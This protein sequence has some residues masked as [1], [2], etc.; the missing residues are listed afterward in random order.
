MAGGRWPV[1]RNRIR[2]RIRIRFSASC[3][4]GR[5]PIT[6]YCDRGCVGQILHRSDVLLAYVRTPNLAPKEVQFESYAFV[7]AF[8]KTCRKSGQWL[9]Y[10]RLGREIAIGFSP[11]IA[12]AVKYDLVEMDYSRESQLG[13]VS[14]LIDVGAKF[15]QAFPRDLEPPMRAQRERRT[16]HI[17]SLFVPML[18]ARFKHPSFAEEEEWHL[19]AQDLVLNGKVLAPSTSKKYRRAEDRLVPYD[20][21]S[22][23]DSPGAVHE[24]VVGYSCP[25]TVDAVRRFLLEKGI[26]APVSRSAVPVR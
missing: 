6:V 13:R 22:F 15:V 21:L 7:A 11:A 3:R 24:V 9:H 16:A 2:I 4:D 23:V 5:E 1:G 10:G 14:A 18:A 17:V 8:C 26:D 25:S 12:A 20:E 19:L